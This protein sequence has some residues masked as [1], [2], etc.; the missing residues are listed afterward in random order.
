LQRACCGAVHVTSQR[1]PLFSA[2][3]EVWALEAPGLDVPPVLVELD[4]VEELW[5]FT[6]TPLEGA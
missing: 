3:Q 4:I 5:E 6:D 1:L 2:L